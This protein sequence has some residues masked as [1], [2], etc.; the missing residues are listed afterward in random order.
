M[1]DFTYKDYTEEET[2]IYNA[3]MDKIM[4]GLEQGLPFTESCEHAIVEDEQLRRFIID[5]A[6]KIMI[7]DIHYKRGLSLGHVADA[8][9]VSIDTINKANTEMLEDIEISASGMCTIGPAGTA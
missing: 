7:A 9:R 2:E 6:L 8:L 3:A 4:E 1:K 5:D